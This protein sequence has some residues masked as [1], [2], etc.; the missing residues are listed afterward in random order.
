MGGFLATFNSFLGTINGVIWSETTLF[1]VLGVGILFTVWTKGAPI[2]AL[3]HGFKVLLGKYDKKDDPG[4][5]NHFQALSAALSAT[6]GLGNIG[7]VAIAVGLGG[8]GAV[9]WMWVVGIIGMSLKTAEVSMAMLFRN[10]DNPND[11]L[12]GPMWVAKLGFKQLNPGLAT[13]GS[14]VGVIF[15]ITLLIAAFTG[16]NMFQSWNVAE[17]T[18]D[19]FAVPKGITGGILA[20]VTGAVIIGGIKRIGAVA[21]KIVPFMCGIYILAGLYVVVVNLGEIPT[22]ISLIFTS[23][24][25]PTEATGAFLGGSMGYAFLWGMK[26]ALF[27]NEAGQGSAPIAHSA[28]KTD[29]PIREGVLAGLGPFI[30]TIIVCSITAFVILA[31]GAWNRAPIGEFASPPSIMQAAGGGWSIADTT[32]NGT[33]IEGEEWRD[34]QRVMLLLDGDLDP[35]TNNNRHAIYGEVKVAG[36]TAV[37]SNWTSYKGKA[38]P[39]ILGSEIYG[40]YRGAS[41]TAYAFDRVVPGLGMWMVTFAS[42]LFA[43]STMISWSYYGEQG[44]RFLAGDKGVMPYKIFY[45]LAIVVAS[46][47]IVRTT[48]ELGNLTDLGTGVMLM[49][50]IPIMLLMGKLTMDK[51]HEYVRKLKNGEFVENP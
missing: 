37:A 41:L 32:L 35:E 30:D 12:G 39:T 7:G 21:G 14:V 43:I 38:P 29:E 33:P 8:P 23:A 5:I 20:I 51:Y 3:T 34:G 9:F 11:P 18:Y 48:E 2:L 13:L 31:T 27:S 1:G 25:S 26:R 24:F 44:I 46:L 49:A 22:V 40:E 47:P 17:I 36:E 42:W 45:C 15:C 6:V 16:G 4:A 50:N 10:T 28:A 19:Y